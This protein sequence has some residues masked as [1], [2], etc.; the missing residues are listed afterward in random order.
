M[1][2][3][4]SGAAEDEAAIDLDCVRIAVRRRRR[5]PVTKLKTHKGLVADWISSEKKSLVEDRICVNEF[6]MRDEKIQHSYSPTNMFGYED[7]IDSAKLDGGQ[8][9]RI[10]PSKSSMRWNL[11]RKIH[12][13]WVTDG[14]DGVQLEKQTERVM[15]VTAAVDEDSTWR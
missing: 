12:D 15:M 6:R 5:E 4:N 11:G 14:A 7:S 10:K 13:G 9:V 1:W 2:I 8:R 3:W